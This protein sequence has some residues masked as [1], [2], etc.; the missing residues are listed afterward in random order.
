MTSVLK[1]YLKDQILEEIIGDFYDQVRENDLVKH[2]F[3]AAKKNSILANLKKYHFYL[4]EKSGY[5][6]SQTP[7]PSSNWDIQLPEMQFKEV[8]QILGKILIFKKINLDHIPQL[9]HEILEIIEETRSQCSETELSTLYLKEASPDKINQLLT[10]H[11][12]RSEVMPSREMKTEK[13]LP[14]PV[15]IG[16]DYDKINLIIK[17]KIIFNDNATNKEMLDFHKK[18]NEKIIFL[19]PKI[20]FEANKPYLYDHHFLPFA[21]GIPIRLLVRYLRRFSMEFSQI[22]TFD[23]EKILKV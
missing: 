23:N 2:Y 1:N 12:I 6:Y 7:A 5:D 4:A 9:K 13:G 18:V 21:G 11:R 22:F 16:I 19:K 3:L 17:S 20:E 8:V 10:R 15:W 14:H